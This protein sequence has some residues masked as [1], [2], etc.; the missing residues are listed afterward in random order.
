[1]NVPHPIRV[2]IAD[3][4]KM[5]RI[6]VRDLLSAAA[7]I[8]L[9][10]EAATAQETI[11][12]TARWQPHVVLLDIRLPKQSG[13]EVC[14]VLK[15]KFP[16]VRVLLLTAFLDEQLVFQ[17]IAAGA[18]GYLLKHIEDAD[19]AAAIR[20][21][22]AGE[23]VLDSQATRALL[24]N[25]QANATP[26]SRVTLQERRILALVAAGLTNK[27]IGL[28]INLAEKTVR[29]YLTVAMEKLGVKRRSEA[30]VLYAQNAGETMLLTAAASPSVMEP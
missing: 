28:R 23:A 11:D 1:M 21:V 4:H 6:G 27:E 13:L 18:D 5:I 29:N 8:L 10:G 7:D 17:A 20:K 2:L 15:S 19:L 16:E 14:R 25:I 9:V 24:H 3:D 22:A 26:L 12:G 30:A